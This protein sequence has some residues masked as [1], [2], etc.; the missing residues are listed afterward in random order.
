MKIKNY[1]LGFLLVSLVAGCAVLDNIDNNPLV[2][3]LAVSQAVLRYIDAGDT[4]V[5]IQER[6]D[7]VLAVM[8]KTLAYIDNEQARA[9]SVMTVLLSM[10]DFSELSIADR[11]LAVE[12]IGLVQYQLDVRIA[13][14][15]LPSDSLLMLRGLVLTA[16]DA[17]RFV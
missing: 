7:N 14:G 9:E 12:A 3:R 10:I 11:A 17:A 8:E 1:I 2:A 16:I 15:E 4:P 13:G 5:V 6:R